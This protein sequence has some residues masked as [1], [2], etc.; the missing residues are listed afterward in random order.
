MIT[1]TA[2]DKHVE[3]L[4]EVMK[5]VHAALT[6]AGIDYRIVGGM[7]VFFQIGRAHV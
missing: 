1:A 2:Y 6:N 5:R 4:F 7:G 3:Q